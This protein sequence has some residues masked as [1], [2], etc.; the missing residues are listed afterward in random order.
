MFTFVDTH[1]FTAPRTTGA[2]ISAMDMDDVQ[3]D[4]MHDNITSNIIKITLTLAL[5]REVQN[6]SKWD[7]MAFS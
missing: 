2:I 5:G 3:E 1:V 4:G 7:A 6:Y